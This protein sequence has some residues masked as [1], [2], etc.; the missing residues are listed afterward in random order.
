VA[1]TVHPLDARRWDDLDALFHAKGCS[2]ARG[3]WCMYYRETAATALGG[4]DA[5]RG[6]LRDLSGSDPAI[7]LLAY[8]AGAP[9]GWVA[10]SP[11][12]QYPR[13]VRSPVA[14]A[15]DDT[16]V[17][18]L[19]CFVV[20]S[21]R[22]G[23]GV[24]RTLLDAAVGYAR[25]QGATAL[26]AYPLDK[27]P[28]GAAAWLWNG[29]VSTYRKA[30][31]VEVARRRPERPVV[32]RA[33]RGWGDDGDAGADPRPQLLERLH[34]EFAAWERLLAGL[35][36]ERLHAPR[37]GA[38]WSIRDVVGHLAGWQEVTL[39]R[40]RAAATGAAATGGAPAFPPW[41]GERSPRSS[42]DLAAANAAL[43]ALHRQRPWPTLLAEWRAGGAETVTRTAR[44]PADAV[45]PSAAS[46]GCPTTRSPR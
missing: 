12:G 7:G 21:A 16:P 25:A 22:R 44:L 17:W 8:E 5:R 32:R 10:L 15:V 6:A 9:V 40:L 30:G 24:A 27:D 2:M 20:P 3:C 4:A 31:F 11:R 38:G 14:K 39:A 26:E 42:E 18:S 1:V 28:P 33:F 23:R 41:R 36:R 43:H 19:V 35:D 29:A 45:A 37:S 13:L 46:R 34:D